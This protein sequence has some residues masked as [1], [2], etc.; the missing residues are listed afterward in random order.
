YLRAGAVSSLIEACVESFISSYD[1]IMDGK[2]TVPL[3]LKTD[4][5]RQIDDIVSI[6]NNKI[7]VQRDKM[8]IEAAGCHVIFGLLREFGEMIENY[9]ERGGAGGLGMKGRA[10]YNLLPAEFKGRMESGD[11]Y[12]SFLVLVD[13][14]SG[15]T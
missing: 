14:V 7:Y 1:L 15:M 2:N 10:L 6:S 5:K 9:M 11:G 8:E 3:L 13:Y 12:E 4:F